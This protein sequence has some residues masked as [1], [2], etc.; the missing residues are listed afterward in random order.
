MQNTVHWAFDSFEVNETECEEIDQKIA[1]NKFHPKSNQI[2]PHDIMLD[3]ITSK[4]NTT[5]S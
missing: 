3:H 2:I 1:N 5:G 4:V